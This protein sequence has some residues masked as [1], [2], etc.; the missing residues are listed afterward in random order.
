MSETIATVLT[1]AE[2][3]LGGASDSP[4]LDAEILLAH[5]L[6]VARSHLRDRKSTRLNSSH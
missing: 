1:E 4:R 6:D 3:A 5:V 2:H